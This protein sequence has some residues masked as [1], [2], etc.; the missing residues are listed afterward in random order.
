MSEGFL[1]CARALAG[2]VEKGSFDREPVIFPGGALE[3]LSDRLD[4]KESGGALPRKYKAV[5]LRANVQGRER[6][7]KKTT[8]SASLVYLCRWR[9][10]VEKGLRAR[11]G[12]KICV[13]ASG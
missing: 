10:A 1:P 5:W 2:P 11:E 3:F 7:R 13:L 4:E 6:E 9:D 12:V 8:T